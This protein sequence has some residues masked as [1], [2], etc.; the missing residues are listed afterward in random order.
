MELIKN[1]KKVWGYGGDW[2]PEG[3]P[4]DNNFLCN[5]LVAPD[6]VW[7]PHA[8]EVQRVYQHIKFKM[9]DPNSG[10]LKVK[11]GYFFKDLSNY[12]LSFKV[13]KDGKL[14]QDGTPVQLHAKAGETES[15]TLPVNAISS[16]GEYYLQVGVVVNDQQL[17]ENNT[18]L[19]K[20]EFKLGG[21]HQFNYA[22]SKE[23]ITAADKADILELKNKNF[24]LQFDK[25]TGNIISY[26][27]NGKEIFK[28][29][30]QPNFW[31]AP[32]DND[33]G[34]GFQKQ[35]VEWKD[36]GS[37]AELI[38]IKSDPQNADG[39]L[40]VSVFKNLLK[41]DATFTQEF[42]V[43]GK[44]AIKVTNAFNAEKGKHAMLMRFGNHS[45]LPLDFINVE[46]YGRGPVENYQDRKTASTVGLYNGLIKDQYYPYIRPQESG[47]KTDVRWAKLTRKDGSGLMIVS[48]D[49]LL[50]INAIPYSAEQLFSGPEKQQKHSGELEP[51]KNVHL[52]IDLEQMGVGGIN[53]W[54]S[55]PLEKYR[56]P[57]KDYHYSY[58]LIPVS[59]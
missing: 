57:Y 54:G 27:A 41:G 56:L 58:L 5:G 25:K 7:N 21:N 44:G 47:N 4:S 10:Q 55:W 23:K 33:Y 50:N 31:R 20:D 29:G 30:P 36:A 46:W 53:S 28:S 14:I 43:D 9:P 15:I 59:K 35:L 2:G 45:L 18:L 49:T 12:S 39:W 19:A 1:G 3:T 42:M 40:K 52:D 8:Y 37:N 26:K 51:D 38:N 34:A 13:F 48:L 24:S 22:A 6:R 17:L 32:N 11:N 16:D